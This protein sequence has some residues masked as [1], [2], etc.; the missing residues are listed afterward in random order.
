MYTYVNPQWQ[1]TL[2]VAPV[3]ILYAIYAYLLPERIHLCLR[4]DKYRLSVCVQHT[5]DDHPNCFYQ[6]DIDVHHL[7]HAR[8]LDD[9]HARRL[10]SSWGTHWRCKEVFDH[11][12]LLQSRYR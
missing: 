7:T 10:S 3:E 4:E 5:G 1:S 8:V 12:F 6:G 2:F 9:R 11:A